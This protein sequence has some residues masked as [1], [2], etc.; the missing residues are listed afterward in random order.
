VTAVRVRE[1][2]APVEA[3]SGGLEKARRRGNDSHWKE[4]LSSWFD[5]EG[6][7]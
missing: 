4:I 6:G 2:Q 7:V 5:Q 3:W 1:S